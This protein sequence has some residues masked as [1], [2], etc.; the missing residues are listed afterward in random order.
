[1]TLLRK[2]EEQRKTP[3]NTRSIST[4]EKEF[5]KKKELRM[6]KIASLRRKRKQNKKDKK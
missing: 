2:K 5:V 4:K 1:M 3:K 6:K